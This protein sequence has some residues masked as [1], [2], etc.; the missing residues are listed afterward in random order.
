MAGIEEHITS[1]FRGTDKPNSEQP[2]AL[3]EANETLSRLYQQGHQELDQ[4]TYMALKN[5]WNIRNSSSYFA[6]GGTLIWHALSLFNTVKD[7]ILDP[8]SFFE[9]MAPPYYAHHTPVYWSMANLVIVSLSSSTQTVFSA[10]FQ[11][12][13]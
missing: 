8:L 10:P 3:E 6:I 1:Y 12:I 13:N 2:L 11:K 9:R 7:G 5:L 4:T